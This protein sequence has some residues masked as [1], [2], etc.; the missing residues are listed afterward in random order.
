MSGAAYSPVHLSSVVDLF[1][2]AR[3]A[4]I[5]DD[6]T[7]VAE[8][9]GLLASAS[10]GPETAARLWRDERGRLVGFAR[11][12]L[13][14]APLVVVHPGVAPNDVLGPIADWLD[15]QTGRADKADSAPAP[16][17]IRWRDDAP[18]Y[19]E[20]IERLGFV[21]EDEHVLLMT[22][23]LE[24]PIPDP[25]LPPGFTIRPVRGEDEVE[26]YVALHRAAFGTQMMTVERR[27][28]IMR[29]ADYVPEIDLVA[30]APGGILA[31]F[32]RGWIEGEMNLRLG[33][34]EAW[35]DPVGTRPAFRRLG[36]NRA[37]FHAAFRRLRERE[38]VTAKL[39][40]GSGNTS[41]QEAFQSVGFLRSYRLRRFARSRSA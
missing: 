26:A 24:E 15:E 4:G 29:D 22:R 35:T 32:V 23:S 39:G 12:R 41:A 33:Q 11:M 8:V 37:L 2:A 3:R 6:W 7:T 38:I 25:A 5:L 18:A 13:P 21:P 28:E 27:R 1:I 31:G 30:V 14:G 19:L 34:R 20:A 9:R 40:T 17:V 10:D 36:L 16:L